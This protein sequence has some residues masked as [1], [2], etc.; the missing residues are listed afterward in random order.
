MIILL[1]DGDANQ[2]DGGV[3]NNPCQYGITQAE[4]AEQMNSNPNTSPGNTWIYTIAYG[5]IYAAGQSC[6]DDTGGNLAGLSAQCAMILMA[7]NSVTDTSYAN[8]TAAK[9]ALCPSGVHQASDPAHRYYNEAVNASENV[10][11]QVG[12]SLST[13]RLISDN[14]S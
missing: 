14:A 11:T 10:F 4:S 7:H 13:P 3:T 2:T 1:S 8:D 12:D 9:A 6:T 5:S